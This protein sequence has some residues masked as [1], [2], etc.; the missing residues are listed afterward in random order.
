MPIGNEVAIDRRRPDEKNK[1]RR[2]ITWQQ[3][4]RRSAEDGTAKKQQ[5]GVA[6]PLLQVISSGWEWRLDT[7]TWTLTFW[8]II[9][10]DGKTPVTMESLH[11][12][13]LGWFTASVDARQCHSFN[14]QIL[15]IQ[16]FHEES[17]IQ[18][19]I[20]SSNWTD[21]TLNTLGWLSRRKSFFFRTIPPEYETNSL[22]IRMR[23]GIRTL[24]T[25]C[26]DLQFH[27]SKSTMNSWNM[28]GN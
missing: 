9:P 2:S 20:I 8:W 13:V 25:A 4:C 18:Q 26:I 3:A 11:N 21:L 16:L 19:K 1:R 24:Q 6:N 12:S 17:Y 22:L 28:G 23:R 27:E 5:I 15:S 10:L 14:V 7:S